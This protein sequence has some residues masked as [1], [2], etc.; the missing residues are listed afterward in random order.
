MSLDWEG[1]EGR[2][3]NKQD[4]LVPKAD[5][6]RRRAGGGGEKRGSVLVEIGRKKIQKKPSKVRECYQ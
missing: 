4:L 5:R 2:E 1:R 6:N 3:E